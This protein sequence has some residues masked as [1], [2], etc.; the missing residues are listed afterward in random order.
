MTEQNISLATKLREEFHEDYGNGRDEGTSMIA[1]A[2]AAGR[3][4]GEIVG[5]EAADR[6]MAEIAHALDIPCKTGEDWVEAMENAWGDAFCWPMGVKFHD[7]NAYA[8]YG[9]ALNSGET[10]DQRGQQLQTLLGEATAFLRQVPIEPWGLSGGD[11]EHT[12]RIAQG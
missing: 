11:A 8:Y 9:F 5:A 1:F 10:A 4:L 3:F 6:G 12:L 7:L 2:I